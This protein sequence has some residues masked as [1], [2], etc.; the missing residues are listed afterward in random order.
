MRL[1]SVCCIAALLSATLSAAPAPAGAPV[2][3]AARQTAYT[4][5]AGIAVA[6]TV[7]ALDSRETVISN[8]AETV[9]LPLTVFPES[10]R[11]RIAA[12]YARK[13]GDTTVLHLPADIRRTLEAGE[14]AIR[15]SANRAAKG[16]C[17]EKES[18]DFIESSRRAR[19]EYLDQAVKDGRLTQAERDLLK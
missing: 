10:E 7:I 18:K 9:T 12:D 4:N 15:R 3:G 19:T 8:L 2:A 6:G 16:L 13:T 1:A 14:K 11:K 5:H 17:S